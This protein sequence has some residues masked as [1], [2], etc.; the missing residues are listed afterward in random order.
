MTKALVVKRVQLEYKVDLCKC[1]FCPELSPI[2]QAEVAGPKD[3]QT[4]Y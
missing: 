4:A 3:P 2:F 1:L